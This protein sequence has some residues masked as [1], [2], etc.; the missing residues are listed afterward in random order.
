MDLHVTSNQQE[1]EHRY[2]Y[3]TDLIRLCRQYHLPTQGTKAELNHYLRLYLS[4]V[5]VQTIQSA[6]V[7]KKRP[8]LSADQIHL[9]T[10]LV[11]SGFSFNNEARKWFANYFGVTHF[12]FKKEM[13]VIKRRAE[14][15]ND[16]T[17]TV[18]D[19]IQQLVQN[20]K[21]KVS[22][23]NPEE[24]TYQWNHFVTDFCQSP[25]SRQ[26]HDKLKVASILWQ[27]VKRSP[28]SKR[29]TAKMVSRFSDEL[30]PFR[31]R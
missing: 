17:M 3:K 8:P 4:G 28:E 1:F 6:R 2:Y 29:Y 11:G 5:P 22:E 31:I 24:Q 20:G 13:A 12:S 10:K 19:L 14:A 26:Y 16:P 15:E 9:E 30:A 7:V 25:E 23:S 27:H 21:T 18:G